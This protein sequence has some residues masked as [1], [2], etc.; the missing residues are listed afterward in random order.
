MDAEVLIINGH[1]YTKYVQ[2]RGFGWAR[3]DVDSSKSTRVK[4]E[5]RMRRDK[6]ATK[7]KISLTMLPMPI[8]L[9]RQLD[10]DL[11][12]DTYFATYKDLHGIMTREFYTTTFNGTLSE[13][14]PDGKEKWNNITFNM[15]EV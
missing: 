5:A 15:I 7:R 3:N 11:S 12:Q 10:D 2:R 8:E 1:D 9:V 14:Q 6:I 4:A 13:I